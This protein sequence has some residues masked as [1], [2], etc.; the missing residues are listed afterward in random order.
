MLDVVL[1]ELFKDNLKQLYNQWLLTGGLYFDSR[2]NYQESQC[3]SSLSVD[4]NSMAAH[5]ISGIT[6]SLYLY[7]DQYTQL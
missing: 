2:Q 4:I 1:N 6:L 7:T 3:D 5:F